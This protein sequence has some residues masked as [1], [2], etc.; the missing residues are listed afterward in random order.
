MKIDVSVPSLLS[1][2]TNGKPRF[3]IEAD[4]LGEALERLFAAYPLLRRHLYTEQGEL[5]KHVL[6]FLNDTNIQW[7]NSLDV[8]LQEGDRLNV[9]QAVS[10]G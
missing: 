10:G 3:T 4:T 8:P 6:L 5:R 1:D 2:C 9:L 7:L